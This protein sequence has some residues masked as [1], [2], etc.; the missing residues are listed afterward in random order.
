[1][2]NPWSMIKKWIVHNPQE[3]RTTVE[4]RIQT[5]LK[6]ELE[7]SLKN[8]GGWFSFSKQSSSSCWWSSL[9]WLDRPY[10]CIAISRDPDL[11]PFLSDPDSPIEDIDLPVNGPGVLRPGVSR[12]GNGNVHRACY[13]WIIF[14]AA[15]FLCKDKVTLISIDW[16]SFIITLMWNEDIWK[17]WWGWGKLQWWSCHSLIQIY[18][19]RCDGKNDCPLTETSAGGEDEEN[20]EG[21]GQV[22]M[23]MMSLWR[24]GNQPL[25]FNIFMWFWFSLYQVA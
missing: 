18:H 24:K 4:E 20:C 23:M 16:V 25:V 9:S 21:S 13:D 12:L 14:R 8:L 19:Q 2:S 10:I 22:M 15:N 5:L 3:L 11:P 7:E 17:S 6:D 1:M